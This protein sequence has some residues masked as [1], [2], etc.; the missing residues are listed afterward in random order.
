M[1]DMLTVEILQANRPQQDRKRI[2]A[3]MGTLEKRPF[4]TF[5][6]KD[7]APSTNGDISTSH[8]QVKPP[9]LLLLMAYFPNWRT[10]VSFLES[11][12]AIQL[13]GMASTRR[14]TP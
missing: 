11:C 9:S 10:F 12:N 5:E 8:Q 7:P 1:L 3:P 2:W 14:T 4:R 6:L 13:R